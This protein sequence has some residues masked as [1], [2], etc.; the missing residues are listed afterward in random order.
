MSTTLNNIPPVLKEWMEEQVEDGRYASED[1]LILE[2]LRTYYLAA[3]EQGE[4]LSEQ[5]R[6]ALR[7]VRQM[8]SDELVD[9]EDVRERAS[10]DDEDSRR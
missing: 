7:E 10:P 3:Q 2:A 8:D 5:E 4:P 6:E 1:D 9:H